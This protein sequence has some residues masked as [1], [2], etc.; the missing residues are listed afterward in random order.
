MPALDRAKATVVL[1]RMKKLTEYMDPEYLV[2]DSTFV[3]KQLQQGKVAMANL[4]ASRAGAVND[5]AESQFTG[6]IKMAAG[7]KGSET[8]ASTLWWDGW[9]VAKNTSDEE[10][11]A[12][13]KMIVAAMD[14][15]IISANND[16]AVW[17]APGFTPG[18]AA[19]GAVATAEAGTPNY[20]ASKEMA[21]M[22]GALGDGLSAYLTGDKDI[23]TTLADIEAAYI[24][25][26]KEAGLIE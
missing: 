23:E 22:H 19:V 21:A 11:E 15:S 9:V 10:A 5:P 8:L 16:A 4:W 20:P 26:A 1:E 13:F 17:L 7:L 25:D 14:P 12:G 24:A 3:T 6:K 2:A 18:D